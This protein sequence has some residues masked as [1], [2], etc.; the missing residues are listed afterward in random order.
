[1]WV[2]FSRRQSAECKTRLVRDR[3]VQADQAINGIINT[4]SSALRSCT[5]AC[6][7][8]LANEKIVSW[9]TVVMKRLRFQ[10]GAVTERAN[11]VHECV[12]QRLL[13]RVREGG[14]FCARRR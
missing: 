6:V 11:E 9:T 1:M 13:S 5:R 12:C 10:F 14:V 3:G 2:W 4:S 8:I 7:H